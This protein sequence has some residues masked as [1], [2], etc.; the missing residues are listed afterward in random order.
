[1]ADRFS[2]TRRPIP[3]GGGVATYTGTGS[4]AVTVLNNATSV[5]VW[6][7]T[8]AY[9]S[10]GAKT[11][12]TTSDMPLPANTPILLDCQPGDKLSAVQVATGGNFYYCNMT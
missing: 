3:S 11:V 5:L 9:V 1:M 8:D 6:V 2:I 7:S 12:A 10:V 4:T